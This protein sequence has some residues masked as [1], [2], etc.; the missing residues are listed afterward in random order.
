MSEATTPFSLISLDLDKNDNLVSA[1]NL[2]IGTALKEMLKA[3]VPKQEEK[4]LFL[5]ECKSATIALLKK[6]QERSPLKYPVYRNASSLS[7]NNMLLET[8]ASILKFRA[9]AESLSKAKIISPDHA[10]KA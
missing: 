4:R 8:D 10:D 2:N 7:P 1:N 3:L 9:L 6:L 5:K